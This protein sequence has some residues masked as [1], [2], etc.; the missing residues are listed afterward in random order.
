MFQVLYFFK[1]SR[2]IFCKN[3]FNLFFYN[4][5][6][7]KII[8][9]PSDA[10]SM[11][12]S[13][14]RPSVLY[15][16]LLDFRISLPYKKKLTQIQHN[17]IVIKIVIRHGSHDFSVPLFCVYAVSKGSDSIC[18]KFRQI[19]SCECRAPRSRCRQKHKITK[20]VRINSRLF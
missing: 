8:L 19:V 1:I 7:I 12:W 5:T 13:T 16:R 2:K 4:F 9:E 3:P 17:L 20:Y 6:K 11:R 14:Q 10:W 15:W 18:L